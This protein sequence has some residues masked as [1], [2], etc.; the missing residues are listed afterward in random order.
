MIF[1]SLRLSAICALII[2]PVVYDSL[3]I[4]Q[5][6]ADFVS[7]INEDWVYQIIHDGSNCV[8]EEFLTSFPTMPQTVS[9]VAL[10]L[11]KLDTLVAPYMASAASRNKMQLNAKS[12]G[13][14]IS[15][16]QIVLLLYA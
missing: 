15:H 16:F 11:V 10:W 3:Y 1:V 7:A 12:K 14:M 8:L 4:F 13:A 9:A 5:V 2:Q 6:L